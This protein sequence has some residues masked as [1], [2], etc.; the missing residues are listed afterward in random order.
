MPDPLIPQGDPRFEYNPIPGLYDNLPYIVNGQ[1]QQP[2]VRPQEEGPMITQ[3]SQRTFDINFGNIMTSQIIQGLAG[4]VASNSGNSTNEALRRFNSQYNNLPFTANN[5]TQALYG[6]K[7]GGKVKYEDGGQYMSEEEIMDWMFEDEGSKQPEQT[8]QVKTDKAINNFINGSSDED[9]YR[10]IFQTPER[11]SRWQASRGNTTSME[12]VDQGL[13][14][15]FQALSDMFP[16]LKVTS[17]TGGKHM[18][19][20]RHDSGRAI[21]I[22]ANSSDRESYK[23]MSQY[24]KNNPAFRKAYGIE[25]I[26]DEGDHTHIELPKGKKGGIHIKEENRGKFTEAANRAGMGVQEYARHVLADPDASATMKKRANFARNASK[27]KHEDGGEIQDDPK[28]K[29]DPDPIVVNNPNDPRLKAYQ[30]SLSLYNTVTNQLN[31]NKNVRPDWINTNTKVISNEEAFNKIKNSTERDYLGTENDRR[32]FLISP[33]NK[34][35]EEYIYGENLRGYRNLS[36]DPSLNNQSL[37]EFRKMYSAK[38]QKYIDE[39]K[40]SKIQPLNFRDSDGIIPIRGGNGQETV[41]KNG[42][43]F[44]VYKKPVQPVVYKKEEQSQLKRMPV[45]PIDLLHPQSIINSGTINPVNIPQEDNQYRVEYRDENGNLTH[46]D[47]PNEKAGTRFQQ[48]MQGE[49]TGYW[50]PQHA[51]GG[52][53]E[54]GEYDMSDEEIND[55]IRRGYKIEKL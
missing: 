34:D 8:E 33:F 5:S 39:I 18:Q 1:F 47:F 41:I 16:G 20:S 11:V 19:G 15:A 14:S 38:N 43:M 27:W 10:E 54:G 22:G 23:A 24:L 17:T 42:V 13:N 46:Q 6:K 25:D 45:S 2:P 4:L 51:M 37:E 26:I 32:K 29:K 48:A 35:V 52:Y 28:K 12:G 49:R 44:P 50:L 40:K 7:M 36:N 30:D 9:L 31:K 21:D 55:L 53:V 3:K